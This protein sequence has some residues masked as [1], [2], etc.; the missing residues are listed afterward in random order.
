MFLNY[1]VTCIAV[2]RQLELLWFMQAVPAAVHSVCG[3]QRPSGSEFSPHGA[4]QDNTRE[5]PH[6]QGRRAGQRHR[7]L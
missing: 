4:A 7:S 1:Y 3:L 6:E 2:A 5:L